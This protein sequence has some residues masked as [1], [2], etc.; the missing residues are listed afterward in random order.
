MTA[1]EARPGLWGKL[2]AEIRAKPAELTEESDLWQRLTD[3][4]DPAIFT[5]KLADDIEIKEFKLRW[6]NDYTM[7]ANPR[8][9][10]HYRIEPSDT[11]MVKLMDGTRSVQEIVA[12]RFGETG[13]LELS[14]L[15]DLVVLL[16]EG[17]F[18]DR[19]YVN[20]DDAIKRAMN[21][22]SPMRQKGRQFARSLSIEWTDADRPVKWLYNH[23]LKWF[24]KKWVQIVA[25]VI[26]LVGFAAFVSIVGSD[27]FSLSGKSL[28]L[29]FVILLFLNYFLTFVHELGHAVVMTHYGRTIKSVGFMIYFGSPAFFVDSSDGLMMD[30]RA[31]IFQSAAG[32]YAEMVISGVA[33]IFAWA[34]P[35]A[36]ISQTLYKFCVLN[37]LVIF[38]NLIPLLEL[39]GYWILS[40]AIQVPNLRPMAMS[41]V[42]HD[43]WHKLR[44]KAHFTK[45]EVGLAVYGILG[46]LFT[47][48]ALFSAFFFWKEVFGGLVA[49]LWHGGVLTRVLLLGLAIFVLGPILRGL[50]NLL[51]SLGRRLKAL[52]L[53]LRFRLQSRW[54]VEAATL[55]DALPVFDDVPVE[56]LDDL[57]GRVRLRTFGR[58]QPVVRQG[59][60]AE[61]FYVV[62]KGGLQVV[63]EDPETGKER[64][65]RVLRR[66]ESFGEL[67]LM[68]GAR[69]TATVRAQEESEVFEVDKGT[70]DRLLASMM[71]VPEFAP[72]FQEMVELRE[73]RCF[74]HLET[75]QLHELMEHGQWMSLAPGETVFEQGDPGDAFYAI[76][77][78][79]VDVFQDG[80][81][82]RTLGAGSF[83]GEIALLMGVPRTAS[84]R[85]RTPVRTY[86]LDR[87]GF[88]RLVGEAFKRGKLNP[89]IPLDRTAHH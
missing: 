53:Q 14:G 20:V 70:F 9:L 87:E 68:E 23:F 85:A 5:P 34:Y 61:A 31:R 82:V 26:A 27:T 59:D 62:R 10:L 58:G 79:Q 1:L 78:G 32:P 12:E 11:E 24:F 66:G 48:V 8:D 49:R 69:R 89:T 4:V 50:I 74:A 60:R 63:E 88:S 6:G 41:F 2:E 84:I 15:A 51:R 47:V 77:S 46:S 64:T 75:D 71:R 18:L 25:G 39:D 44:A 7:L 57:A 16:Y 38:L 36:A 86:R 45:Q 52:L 22:I 65:L 30:R 17:N 40:D 13:E 19:P 83:F 43:L 81:L 29:G 42:R 80:S 35:G 76:G 33:A 56:V 73:L 55:I 72:S 3:M 21:P 28:A 54:R 67:A 37:Y